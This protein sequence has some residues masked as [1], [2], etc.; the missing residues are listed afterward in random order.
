MASLRHHRIQE[1][2]TG[3]GPPFA[4][5]CICLR[6]HHASEDWM[7]MLPMATD[8]CSEVSYQTGS[9]IQ[10]GDVDFVE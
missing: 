9:V 8:S 10:A 3:R 1:Q 7:I 2:Q 4:S 6:S 5:F